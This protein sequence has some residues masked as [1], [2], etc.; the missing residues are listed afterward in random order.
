MKW[1]KRERRGDTAVRDQR[2]SP[3]SVFASPLICGNVRNRWSIIV[4]WTLTIKISQVVALGAR[5]RQSS[6]HHGF[7]LLMMGME[8]IYPGEK[9][10]KALL[11]PV[12]RHTIAYIN[13]LSWGIQ[14]SKGLVHLHLHKGPLSTLWPPHPFGSPPDEC[15]LSSPSPPCL[16]PFGILT[17]SPSS[18]NVALAHVRYFSSHALL[19]LNSRWL[20]SFSI[21]SIC[22]IQKFKNSFLR[23]TCIA[24]CLNPLWHRC[25]T[26][27]QRA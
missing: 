2:S 18:S 24:L 16:L 21:S 4:R 11:S 25:I 9:Q 5:E 12:R 23:P 14:V 6:N 15:L 20:H 8:L 17:T 22:L 19:H 3:S 26:C 10:I 1:L 27:W 13:I 7:T